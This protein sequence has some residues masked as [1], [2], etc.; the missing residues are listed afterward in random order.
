[1][2]NQWICTNKQIKELKMLNQWICTNKTNKGV[3]DAEAVDLYKY[4]QL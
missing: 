4:I 3:K 1:M 2:L